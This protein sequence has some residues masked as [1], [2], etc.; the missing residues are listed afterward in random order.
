[1]SAFVVFSMM[2]F[3]PVTPGT[4]TYAIGSPFF[5]KT[6]LHLPDGKTFTIKAKDLSAEN[7]FIQSAKL[8]GKPL[9]EPFLTHEQLTAG[10]TLELK[11]VNKPNKE[12]FK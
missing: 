5:E 7:K 12:T 10:G 3:F 1:M 11:M 9:T 8:N 2:G 6:T 4:T